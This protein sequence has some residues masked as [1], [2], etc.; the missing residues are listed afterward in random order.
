MEF[1]RPRLY[2]PGPTRVVVCGLIASEEPTFT[3]NVPPA[4]FGRNPSAPY[5]PGPG[6]FF[7]GPRKPPL[8][9]LLPIVFPWVPKLLPTAYYPGPGFLS[10][11]PGASLPLF[12]TLLQMRS[13]SQIFVIDII[14][15]RKLGLDFYPLCYIVLDRVLY[16]EI[17]HHL[18]KDKDKFR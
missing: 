14:L 10:F 6:V 12:D 17:V 8:S 16:H 7:F 1:P 11:I 3:P 9:V 13:I 18:F 4:V 2:E 15:T 5:Y